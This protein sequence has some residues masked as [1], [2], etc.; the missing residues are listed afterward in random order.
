MAHAL[1][2]AL[3]PL[4]ATAT[5]CTPQYPPS[6]K[7][8]STD[9]AAAASRKCALIPIHRSPVMQARVAGLVRFDQRP[10][11][12]TKDFAT[13]HN[14]AAVT[15]KG[16]SPSTACTEQSSRVS[17]PASR[18]ESHSAES[19]SKRVMLAAGGVISAPRTAPSVK[20]R[21]WV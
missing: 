14:P 16:P 19:R 3:E 18:Q 17:T 8:K 10:A 7:Y 5:G 9:G 20:L 6:K 4:L 1:R 13:W 11:A 15:M 12:L 21:P 2:S